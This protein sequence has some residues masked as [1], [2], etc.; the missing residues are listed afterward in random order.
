MNFWHFLTILAAILQVSDQSNMIGIDVKTG[1]DYGDGMP[2]DEGLG[3]L[4]FQVTLI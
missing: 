1:D 4:I 3:S 2:P